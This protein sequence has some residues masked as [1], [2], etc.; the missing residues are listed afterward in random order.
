MDTRVMSHRM[1]ARPECYE[2]PTYAVTCRTE[3]FVLHTLIAVAGADC[4]LSRRLEH[5]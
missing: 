3:Q 5:C 4:F 1:L 2:H